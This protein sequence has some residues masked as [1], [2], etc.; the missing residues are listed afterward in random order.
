MIA[1]TAYGVVL[2]DREELAKL[3]PVFMEPPYKAP[4]S[5]PVV[6]IKPRNCFASC[7]AAVQLDHDVQHVTI[8]STLAL[9]F[10]RDAS[11]TSENSGLRYVDAACLAIDV[12][13]SH[14]SY[15]RPPIAQRCR[16]KFL[17]LGG[18]A[19]VPALPLE[20]VTHVD[21]V[22]AHRWSLD[23]LARPIGKLIADLTSFMTLR[24]GDLLMVGLPGDA[25]GASRGQSVTV[26]ATGLRDLT[27]HIEA[28]P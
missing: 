4:P 22:E 27:M 24:A 23:R 26:R 1:G 8:A 10:G 21:G 14:D 13:V 3:R 2:N 15:Y 17:P 20:I 7:G 18:F 16:D 9:F 11:Q 28:A 19:A 25:P 6:Y 5:A 12:S